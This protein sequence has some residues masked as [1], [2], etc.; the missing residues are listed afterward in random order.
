MSID[1]QSFFLQSYRRIKKKKH[2]KSW[3]IEFTYVVHRTKVILLR[4]RTDIRAEPSQPEPTRHGPVM[5]LFDG[6][7][8]KCIKRYEFETYTWHGYW[9]LNGHFKFSKRFPNWFRSYSIFCEDGFLPF[10]HT[11]LR[12]FQEP[13]NL[14]WKN[15]WRPIRINIGSSKKSFIRC[16]N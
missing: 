3:N 1:A 10:L 4:C 13:L 14:T 7:F 5:T 8:L 11:F 9:P 15:V 16:K 6:L 2:H 12:I